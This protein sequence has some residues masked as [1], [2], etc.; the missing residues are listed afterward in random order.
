MNLA[1]LLVAACATPPSSASAADPPADPE[2]VVVHTTDGPLAGMVVHLSAGHGRLLAKNSRGEVITWSWQRDARYG[3]REDEWTA[4]F[5]IDHLAPT[6]EAA[7][8]TVLTL[9][10]RDRADIGASVDDA[11]AGFSVEG[12][13]TFAPD[14]LAWGP[15]AQVLDGTTRATWTVPPMP[16]GT[17][18]VYARWV[19]GPDR[20]P[21]ARYTV[22]GATGRDVWTVD[23]RVHGGVWWP[24]GDV[25]VT[26]AIGATIRLDG[27]GGRL[28]ADAVRIG[29]GVA[30]P[31]PDFE[32]APLH[33]VAPVHRQPSLGGPVDLLWLEDG[34]ESSDIRFRARWASRV[35]PP[36]E[37][38]V[39]LSIHT[40]AGR[41]HGTEIYAGAETSPPMSTLPASATLAAELFRT[42]DASTR[43]IN[44]TWYVE[45]PKRGD[46][47]EISPKWQ[48]L[49]S[50]LLEVGFHDSPA[51]VKWLLRE[52]FRQAFADGIR[53]GLVAWRQAQGGPLVDTGG[54]ELP[55]RLGNPPADNPSGE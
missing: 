5:V 35:S 44:P 14:Q 2:A 33:Q 28:S 37:E 23:Q 30:S 3:M 22:S 18:R 55:I 20:A 38:A 21:D 47:S 13:A 48:E 19:A 10:E 41:A 26:D 40:N 45:P 25:T 1:L 49:P 52:D 32:L 8:A 54:P 11:D 46:F 34:V 4:D 15:G 12:T 17:Y 24:L 29:G 53:D 27:G 43:T 36:P 39:F 6:L 50:A 51:D 31:G 9:R 16:P 42:L 7:G